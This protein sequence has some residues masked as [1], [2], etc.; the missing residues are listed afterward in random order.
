[1][2]LFSY[3]SKFI[4]FMNTLVD[5]FIINLMWLI[6][7][8]PIITVGTS[9]IAAYTVALKIVENNEGKVF[10]QFWK[11][12]KDNFLHGLVLTV[13]LAASVWIV[14]IDFQLFNAVENNPIIFTIC[15]FVLA[16]FVL[17]HTIYIFPLE[18]RYKN[19]LWRALTNARRIALRFYGRT[20]L[21]M[22]VVFLEILLFYSINDVLF[23]IGC[24]IGPMCII[25]TISG[26]V[27]PI[28]HKL[29]KEAEDIA[30]AEKAA[31][32]RENEPEE[33]INYD[34]SN[35]DE[36]DYDAPVVFGDFEDSEEE[37]TEEENPSEE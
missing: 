5:V 14:W 28:F 33:E 26:I 10:Q 27:M 34:Y 23:V 3:D 17:L 2:K 11:A 36:I 9:T 32:E 19:G 21:I 37:S 35:D 29:E 6:G 30:A 16:F 1:M 25:I 31:L 24:L 4:E 20:F 18:A 13:L 15:G 8:V 12:Y 22:C 7:C